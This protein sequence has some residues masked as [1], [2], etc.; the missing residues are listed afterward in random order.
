[1]GGGWHLPLLI[2]A[3]LINGAWGVGTGLLVRLFSCRSEGD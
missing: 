1:M 2:T 3:F